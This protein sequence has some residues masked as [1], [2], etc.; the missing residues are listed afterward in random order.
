MVRSKLV[1]DVFF[2]ALEHYHADSSAIDDVL[3]IAAPVQQSV[4]EFDHFWPTRKQE[5]CSVL[6]FSKK[7][8]NL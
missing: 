1:K 3:S 5:H 8:P 2:P 6:A 4:P 7:E